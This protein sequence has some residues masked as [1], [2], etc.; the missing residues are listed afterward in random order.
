[1]SL[2]SLQYYEN[3]P[4]ITLISQL[5]TKKGSQTTFDDLKTELLKTNGEE[6]IPVHN[7][8]LKEDNDLCLIYNTSFKETNNKD[9]NVSDLENSCRSIVIE[10]N[11]LKPIVT[12][13]N[14]ILYNDETMKF[15]EGKDWSHITVQRCYEGTLLTV[16]NHND[17]WYV[18]TRRCLNAKDS[19][20]VAGNSYYD[21]FTEAM[22]DIFTFDELNK[23][24]CYHFVLV[25]SKNK[26]IVSYTWLGKEYAELFHVMTT[27]KYTL[28][29]IDHKINDNVRRVEEVEFDSLDE[30]IADLTT[31]NNTDVKYQKVTTEGYI[32]RYYFGEVHNSPF[33]NMKLQTEIYSTLM[34][35]KPNNS[36]IHQCFLELYQKDKLNDFLPYFTRYGGEVV[37]R[38][39]NS[40][41]NIA[42]EVLDLYHATR[43]KKNEE[44]YN[45][46]TSVYKKCIYE[47]HGRYISTRKQDFTDGVDTKTVE[48]PRAINVYDV[49]NYLKA[50]PNKDLRQLYFDRIKLLEN[51][52]CT[53]LN[54]KCISTMTQSSLMFK[55]KINQQDNKSE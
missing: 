15:L 25:H 5:N 16:F 36:N 10:K 12:Q 18:T 44:L 47:I 30:L 20:W 35:L 51:P 3:L 1:M 34:N 9:Q 21:M 27:E 22:K 6:N 37:R 17:T 41:K 19:T 2:S 33:M 14:R 43:N 13:F 46:L 45:A 42:K 32:L 4:I 11:T 50:L 40:M 23:N 7:L 49:Y 38:L 55:N 39:H 52:V 53:F 31:Q 54:K 26:N 24:L 28:K 29:E 48:V 8:Q